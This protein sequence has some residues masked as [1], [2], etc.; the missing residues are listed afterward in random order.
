MKIKLNTQQPELIKQI[1]EALALNDGYCPCKPK[2]PEN[3]CICDEFLE[4]TKIG[5]CHCKKYYKEEI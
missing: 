5:Y 3:K 2:K 1:D 4:S